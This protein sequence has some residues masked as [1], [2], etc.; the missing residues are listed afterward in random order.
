MKRPA[1]IARLFLLLLILLVLTAMQS[2]AQQRMDTEDQ[3]LYGPPTKAE[4]IILME[5]LDASLRSLAEEDYR[6]RRIGGYVMMGL[7][8]GTG[9]GGVATLAFGD[10]DDAKI[11]GVSLLG[12]GALLGGLSAIPFNVRSESERLYDEFQDADRDQ[13]QQTYLYWDRRFES[14]AEKSRRGRIVGGITSMVAGGITGIVILNGN[15]HN[16]VE[17]SLW[18]AMGPVM[19]GISSLLIKSEAERRFEAYTHA[20]DGLLVRKRHAEFHAGVFPLPDGS[21]LGTVRVIF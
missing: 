8:I 3:S 13:I 19:G 12:G 17:S 7:G 11:V 21:L 18:A 20:K 10:G 2:F 15:S 6:G 1:H 4:S 16:R 14:F 9:V 5:T